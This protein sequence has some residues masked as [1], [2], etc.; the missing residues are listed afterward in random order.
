MR[1][2]SRAIEEA[3]F[4]FNGEGKER[5]MRGLKRAVKGAK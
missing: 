5:R 1:E 4:G 3:E 2:L